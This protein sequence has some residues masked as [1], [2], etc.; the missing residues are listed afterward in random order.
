MIFGDF[1]AIGSNSIFCSFF[2]DFW[3]FFDDLGGIFLTIDFW[4]F[5]RRTRLVQMGQL[6]SL[7]EKNGSYIK[8][9]TCIAR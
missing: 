5:I 7:G 4:R 8:V 2:G 3:H 9:T 1:L 6:D